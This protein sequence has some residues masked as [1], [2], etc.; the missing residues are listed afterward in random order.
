[1]GLPQSPPKRPPPYLGASGLTAAAAG[2][3]ET[4]ST[5]PSEKFSSAAQPSRA[6]RYS[7]ASSFS[8]RQPPLQR[9]EP[10]L[11]MCGAAP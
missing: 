6:Q 8:G 2:T 4:A 3:I 5:K 1:M 9:P 11:E 7:S 10:A